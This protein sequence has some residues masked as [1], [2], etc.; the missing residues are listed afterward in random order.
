MSDVGASPD[1]E[2]F[3]DPVCPW[4]WI[5]SRWVRNV[6]A[7]KGY[8]VRWRFISLKVLNED[9]TAPDYSDDHRAV[10]VAGLSALRVLDAVRI[11]HGNDAVRR[12]YTATGTAI[13]VDRRRK[14]LIADP[15]AFM[16]TCLESAGVDAALAEHALDDSHDA[17]LRAETA[18]ALERTGPDVGTPILTFVPGQEG[19][20]SFF[21][22]VVNKAPT[23]HDAVRLWEAVETLATTG[24]AELKRS[25]RG[26]IDFT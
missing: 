23:G 24:V 17:H 5:T 11:E 13:H 6:Q 19:E 14:E 1:L 3:L 8:S 9:R 18:A 7:E 2:F 20:G 21:G 16:R 22:P 25:L 12:A 15:V 26:D 4:C 10:H